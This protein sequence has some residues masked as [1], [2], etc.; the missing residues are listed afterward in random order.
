MLIPVVIL[1]NCLDDF[2]TIV[3]KFASYSNSKVL[4][5]KFYVMVHQSLDE[6]NPKK[7]VSQKPHRR[8]PNSAGE[9]DLFAFCIEKLLT[10]RENVEQTKINTQEQQNQ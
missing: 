5:V 9:K 1:C 6:K 7:S 3:R 8:V 10:K 2:W 4:T